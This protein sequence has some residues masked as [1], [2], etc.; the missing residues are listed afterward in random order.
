M[1][2]SLPYLALV[3]VLSATSAFA[4]SKFYVAQKA[5]GGACSVVSKKPDGKTMMMVGNAAYKTLTAANSA[6]KTAPE[7]KKS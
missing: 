7:C 1:R 2:K 5:G 3:M 6:L 4:A